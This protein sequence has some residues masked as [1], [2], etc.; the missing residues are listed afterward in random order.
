MEV[1]TL[2]WNIGGGRIRD[3][4]SDPDGSGSYSKPGLHE[5]IRYIKSK[6]PDIITLQETHADSSAIQAEVIAESLGYFWTNDIY[7]SSHLEDGQGLGQAIISRFPISNHKFELFYNAKF[8]KVW[9]SGEVWISHDKGIS[10]SEFNIKGSDLGVATLHMV[11][12]RKYGVDIQS[13]IAQKVL[14]DIESKMNLGVG[15]FLIQG[16]F[17]LDNS[18]LKPYFPNFISGDNR[19]IE[20][21]SP[22]TPGNRKYDHILYGGIWLTSFA[23]DKDVLCDHYP[24][25]ATFE[26]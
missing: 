20:T 12:F 4:H 15:K 2:Q 26:I 10:S 6:N 9:P 11:P 7:A 5:I 22:T 8:R 16:D 1:K 13:E 25:I 14:L 17:N 24:L 19:E 21:S 18:T 23:I 3:E